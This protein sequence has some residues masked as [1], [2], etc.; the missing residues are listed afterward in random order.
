MNRRAGARGG[1]SLAAATRRGAPPA[2]WPC[3]LPA[4][5][6]ACLAGGCAN[7]VTGM[8]E[9]LAEDLTAAML[10]NVDL[11]V[12]E[13]GAP[14]YLI[15]LD[16]LLRSNADSPGLL[17]AAARLN[18]AYGA[19]F[20]EDEARARGF[21]NK[22]LALGSRAACGEIEWMCSARTMAFAEFES[23][24]AT[25]D[26]ADVP[27]AYAFATA[28]AGWIEANDGD[29]GAVAELGKVKALMTRIAE[30]DETWDNGGP[31]MYLGVFETLAPP[32]LGGRPEV[33]RAHFERAIALSDGRNLMA[34]VLLASNYARLVFDRELHDRVLGEVVAADPR[35]EGLTLS[36][37]VAQEWASD[38]L[39]SADEFFF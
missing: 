9:T 32:A 8:T 31:P 34:S 12:V 14:A 35:V 23:G 28:W 37:R 3:A 29:W 27:A 21:A 16:A 39:A 1:G 4:L 33:G 15:M 2:R 38:L 36:N 18:A 26:D 24:L 11:D 17:R 13:S 25:L 22:A 10:D 30:L 20:A 6:A 7:V 19:A 5:L